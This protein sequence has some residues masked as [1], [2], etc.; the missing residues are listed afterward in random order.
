MVGHEALINLLAS[1]GQQIG[2]AADKTVLAVTPLSFD[3][4]AL[5]IYGSLLAGS[6]MALADQETVKEGHRLAAYIEQTGASV[7]QATPATWRMLLEAGWQRR[8][9]E[10]LCGGE[11]MPADLLSALTGGSEEVWNLYGPTETTVWSTACRLGADQAV[12]IGR[13]ISNTQVYVLDENQEVVPIGV[14]GELYIGGVGLA[15]G[16]L[17]RADLTAER[18]VPS[19]FGA[20]DRLYRTGDAARWGGDGNLEYLGRLDHQVKVRGYR[21]ELGEIEAALRDHAGVGDAVV[22]AREDVPGDKRLVAYVTPDREVELPVA[23]IEFSLFYFAANSQSS[24]DE[25]V[26]LQT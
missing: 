17:G 20:G 1:L 6:R 24:I 19:P 14:Q 18:F 16:Y 7:V 22:V 23:K 21:I 4:A 3:I 25:N 12:R 15:R 8:N 11:A 13:P 9:V 5:E 10:V 2:F 26:I